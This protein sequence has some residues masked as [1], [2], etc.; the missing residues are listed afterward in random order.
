LSY[1]ILMQAT[2]V[3]IVIYKFAVSNYCC[4]QVCVGMM[5]LTPLIVMSHWSDPML[6]IWQ[7]AWP[8]VWLSPL[9]KR[10]MPDKRRWGQA[11]VGHGGWVWG[12]SN[13]ESQRETKLWP[14]FWPNPCSAPNPSS[15]QVQTFV[16]LDCIGS[17]QVKTIIISKDLSQ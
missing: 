2:I 13:K 14:K 7:T 6:W 9:A 17:G 4:M 5:G 16:T 3:A 11:H 10:G 8:M 15:G 1:A 12:V